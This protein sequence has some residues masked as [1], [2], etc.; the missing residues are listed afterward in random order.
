[1][2]CT[3][4][5]LPVISVISTKLGLGFPWVGR[6]G[7]AHH[8]RCSQERHWGQWPLREF[9]LIS[10]RSLRVEKNENRN[11]SQDSLLTIC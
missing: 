7:T 10:F 1:M 2:I 9:P 11:R 5:A 6:I 8:V 3:P 4:L